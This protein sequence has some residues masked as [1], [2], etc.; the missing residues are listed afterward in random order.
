MNMAHYYAAGDDFSFTGES[1]VPFEPQSV[2]DRFVNRHKVAPEEAQTIL[3][4]PIATRRNATRSPGARPTVILYAD[5]QS[6]PTYAEALAR[7][8]MLVVSP[9]RLAEFTREPLGFR[10]NP[11][12]LACDVEDLRFL[13]AS[14]A[15]LGGDT[16][17]P[18]GLLAFS[19]ASLSILT[20]QMRDTRAQAICT[21]EGW[22]GFKKG[23]DELM[24]S[25]HFRPRALQG[26]LLQIEKSKEER[27][28]DYA[29]TE[30]FFAR[31]PFVDRTRL[32][33][34]DAEH[35]TF[36]T[37][38]WLASASRG[39]ETDVRIH[40]DAVAAAVHFFRRTLLGDETSEY[41]TSL[42]EHSQRSPLPSM[43]TEEELARLVERGELARAI[44][45]TSSWESD[46]PPPFDRRILRRVVARLDNPNEQREA[47]EWIARI[48]YQSSR[49]WVDLA[50]LHGSEGRQVEQ[51]DAFRRALDLCDRDPSLDDAARTRLA[52][53]LRA[54]IEVLE[55]DLK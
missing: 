3:D 23:V 30:D 31:A 52:E 32:R 14:L 55:S 50:N 29:K 5:P 1:N 2:V 33:F 39:D 11:Q 44:T 9:S 51:L 40:N 13:H 37:E 19:S 38:S 10:P 27:N 36:L 20:W 24:G 16:R 42:A 28:E 49:A 6:L 47:Y 8:G 34:H 46:A 25:I 22:E 17:Q 43:P 53:G 15:E 21:I 35:A 7:A 4:R 48:H 26:P 45:A 18:L 12:S 41:H 54:E